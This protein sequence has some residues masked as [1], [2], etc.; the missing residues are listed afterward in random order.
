[1]NIQFDHFDFLKRQKI[2]RDDFKDFNKNWK[3]KNLVR[4]LLSASPTFAPQPGSSFYINKNKLKLKSV[5]EHVEDVDERNKQLK[6]LQQ[7]ANL[8]KR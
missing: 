3:L 7:K 5:V 8:L 4:T 6:E 1:M 2:I